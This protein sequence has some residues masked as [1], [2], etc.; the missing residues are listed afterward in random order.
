MVTKR[1]G[2]PL[3]SVSAGWLLLTVVF[4]LVYWAANGVVWLLFGVASALISAGFAYAHYRREGRW[5]VNQ[6]KA[7]PVPAH[8]TPVYK[9]RRSRVRAKRYAVLHGEVRSGTTKVPMRAKGCSVRCRD[10]RL[11]RRFC[12]CNCGGANHGEL[13]GMSATITAALAR[14]PKPVAR[15]TAPQPQPDGKTKAK[16]PPAVRIPAGAPEMPLLVTWKA[17]DGSAMQGRTT[18]AVAET[19]RARGRL[20]KAERV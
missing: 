2:A 4:T 20:V 15:R 5:G 13:R 6:R 14:Q 19:L 11:P 17:D 3:R 18:R 8:K 16:V 1:R 7:V 12:R 9:D 10:S